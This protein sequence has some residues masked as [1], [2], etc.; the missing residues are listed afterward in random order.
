M[1][2]RPDDERRW[3]RLYALVLTVLAL[4]IALFWAITRAYS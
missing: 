2:D 3:R 1:A 4:E